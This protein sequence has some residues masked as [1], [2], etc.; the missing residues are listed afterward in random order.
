VWPIDIYRAITKMVVI[1]GKF[2]VQTVVPPQNARRHLCLLGVAARSI[3]SHAVD[4]NI[5]SENFFSLTALFHMTSTSNPGRR[6]QCKVF[7]VPH[8]VT[9]PKMMIS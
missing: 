6:I 2:F 8:S 9:R 4:A 5:F 7:P 3:Q 1:S